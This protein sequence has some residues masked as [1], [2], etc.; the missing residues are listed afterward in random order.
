[1][2]VHTEDCDHDHD[3]E[4]T[5]EEHV[6]TED[7]TDSCCATE[8]SHSDE[9]VWLSV[10]NA[11][12]VCQAICD[13]ICALDA[14]NA[15]IYQENTANYIQT[16]QDLDIAYE[17]MVE[18]AA[19]DTVIFADRF[20]FLYMMNDYG[21]NYYAAF[22]GCSAETEASF[23]TIVFLANKVD[24]LNANYLIIIDNGLEDLATTVASNSQKQDCEILVLNSMQSITKDLIDNGTTYLSIMQENLDVLTLALSE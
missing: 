12:V 2:H 4:V 13:Q 1:E 10:K 15:A 21:V 16:L 8:D 17:T 20:P 24:E 11:I 6:H 7:C 14:E 22:Q 3:D 5:E 19:R 18:S 23:E 9:H